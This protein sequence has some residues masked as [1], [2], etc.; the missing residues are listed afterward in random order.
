MVA[1]PTWNTPF[2]QVVVAH[3]GRTSFRRD[4]E[5]LV[6]HLPGE[7]LSSV[8]TS[9]RGPEHIPLA[10]GDEQGREERKPVDVIPDGC[11]R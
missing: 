11:A 7:H 4:R 10:A 9:P 6:L 8:R 3:L 1:S 2:D 5:V